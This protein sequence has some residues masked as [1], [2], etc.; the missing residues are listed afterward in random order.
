LAF[1]AIK[2]GLSFMFECVPIVHFALASTEMIQQLFFPLRNLGSYS[3]HGKGISEKCIAT[4]EE[5]FH[6]I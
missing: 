2:N 1:A 6:V 5:M 4:Q 3:N